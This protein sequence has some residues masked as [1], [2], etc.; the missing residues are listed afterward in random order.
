MDYDILSE[1]RSEVVPADAKRKVTDRDR[2][3]KRAAKHV[4]KELAKM[5]EEEARPKPPRQLP[6]PQIQVGEIIDQLEKAP[7]AVLKK[8]RRGLHIGPGRTK[9][10][11]IWVLRQANW[12]PKAIQKHLGISQYYYYKL[13]QRLAKGDKWVEQSIERMDRT[14]IPLAVDSALHH[15]EKYDKQM[16]LEVL[17]G[18]GVLKSDHDGGAAP[19]QQMLM[20]KIE[21]PQGGQ[22]VAAQGAIVGTP[23][24]PR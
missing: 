10:V 4:A 19:A 24:V 21:M 6:E 22:V 7:P 3:A 20:V 18:R 13:C 23:N 16:T 1:M 11:K 14:A 9:M 17:K 5:L 12:E 15:L 8:K 2:Q